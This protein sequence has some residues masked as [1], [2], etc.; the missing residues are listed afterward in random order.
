MRAVYDPGNDKYG[1]KGRGVGSAQK[2]TVVIPFPAADGM[3]RKMSFGM[4]TS[5]FDM[6]AKNVF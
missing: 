2:P 4:T 6:T 5:S 1:Q 3:T